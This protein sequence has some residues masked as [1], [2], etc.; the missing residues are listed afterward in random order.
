MSVSRR[1]VIAALGGATAVGALGEHTPRGVSRP[2]G[3]LFPPQPPM[4]KTRSFGPKSR[5]RPD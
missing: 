3:P 1:Q 5:R 2:G 4:R